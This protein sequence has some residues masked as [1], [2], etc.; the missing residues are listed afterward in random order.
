MQRSAAVVLS[1]P[2]GN[3]QAALARRE[4]PGHRYVNL[5]DT[6]DRLRARADPQAFLGGLRGGAV[7]DE[8]HCA[9]E[10]RAALEHDRTGQWLLLSPV[11][12][13][14]SGVPEL[15]LFPPSLAERE[16]R[17]LP[18][19][20]AIAR[21]RPPLASKPAFALETLLTTTST[22]TDREFEGDIRS[23]I[24][25]HDADRFH[26]F[27]QLAAAASGEVIDQSAWA[28]A[29]GVTH[30]TIARWLRALEQ[31]FRALLLPPS[32]DDFGQR[33]VRRRK[34]YYLD[35]ASVPTPARFDAWCVTEILKSHAHAGDWPR[36][37][38]WL[39]ATGR[40]TGLVAVYD[41]GPVSVSFTRLP[42]AP[43]A[44]LTDAA[45]WRALDAGHAAIVIT[46]G[47]EARGN[48]WPWFAL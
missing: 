37:E 40:E 9:P 44:L 20:Q 3:G 41:E 23:L 8:A 46:G 47:T 26:A 4:F 21:Y 48:A 29:C 22:T 11:R 7:I 16:G 6:A 45:K 13:A 31:S 5:A 19:L 25:L 17:P 18:S 28:R 33:L 39:T 27:V 10:L 1:G 42:A 36:L 15:H 35:P 2:R 30:T 34:L 38:H 24:G 32:S 43:P 12:L 14:W